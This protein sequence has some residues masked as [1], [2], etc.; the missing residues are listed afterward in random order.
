MKTPHWFTRSN[1]VLSYLRIA[2]AGSLVAGAAALGFTAIRMSGP[3]P[4]ADSGRPTQTFNKFRQDA[5]EFFGNK[6]TRPGIS[7]DRGPHGAA[8][9]KFSLRAYPAADVPSEATLNAIASF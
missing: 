3:P 9:E 2:I 4:L 1:S 6:E 8:L 7:R 5:D